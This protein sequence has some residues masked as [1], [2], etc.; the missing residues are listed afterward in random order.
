MSKCSDNEDFRQRG[1][2]KRNCDWVAKKPDKRCPLFD[3]EAWFGCPKTC[4][5]ACALE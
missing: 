1:L 3:E 4:N 5:P 2:E